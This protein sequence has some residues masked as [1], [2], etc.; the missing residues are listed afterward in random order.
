MSEL[1]IC[2]GLMASGKST[3]SRVWV[4]EDRRTR[5]R[6]SRDDLR[7]M[8]EDGVFIKDTTEPKVILAR[9]AIIRAALKAGLDVVCDDTNLRT[10]TVVDLIKLAL[11]VKASWRIEDFTDVT[12]EECLA[13]N[14]ARNLQGPRFLADEVIIKSYDRF[15]RG[16]ELPLPV[17]YVLRDK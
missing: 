15:L 14:A 12:L 11:N 9:N 2:R 6:V 13:R 3:W 4:S 16:K 10:T 1:V 8:L 5:I 17:P 7:D